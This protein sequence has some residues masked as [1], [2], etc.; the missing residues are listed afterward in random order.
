MTGSTFRTP[1]N[2]R[3]TLDFLS[4]LGQLMVVTTEV[5]TDLEIAGIEK[6]LDNGPA[7][8]FENVKG[9]PHARVVGNLMARMETVA[10]MFG[11][12][13]HRK[14]KLR[15]LDAIK[16]PLPPVI[17]NHA[18]CQQVVVAAEDVDVPKML[19]IIKHTRDDA[20]RI[21]GGGVVLFSDPELGKTSDI[22]FRRMH[23]RGKDY[24]SIMLNPV[25]HLTRIM[26]AKKGEKIPVTV[27]IGVSP[28][29]LLVAGAWALHM[30]V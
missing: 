29:V 8:L 21:L 14:L 26:R 28:S 5:D 7:L 24:A 19:P 6:A 2:L 20:G 11:V 27:N 12:S 16:S 13:D 22:T 15:C 9:F 18:P 23:F 1:G 30:I 25:S 17:V 10:A 3:E 4:T